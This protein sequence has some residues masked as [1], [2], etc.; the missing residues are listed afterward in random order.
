MK[1]LTTIL[2]MAFSLAAQ[3][4]WL[5]DPCTMMGDHDKPCVINIEGNK[6][7]ILNN[8]SL[9]VNSN[10]QQIQLPK[11]NYIDW[12]R[13]SVI[14]KN[15]AYLVFDVSDGDYG[16]A[17][18]VSVSLTT[19]VLNWQSSLGG[20]NSS[21][22]L[23]TDSGVYAGAIGTIVKF[24]LKSGEAIWRH[25][26]LYEKDTQAY[27]SFIRPKESK[28]TIIFEESKVSSK[29]KGTRKIIVD[30]RSGEILSK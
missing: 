18:V 19:N 2:A 16:H 4:S 26:G 29:Y 15:N 1:I 24:N 9:A 27:N 11:N 17:I 12:Y 6:F 13:D 23:V 20:F 21:P 25:K 30:D 22:L 7:V 3:S 5:D 14:Y 28:G 10:K 8:G